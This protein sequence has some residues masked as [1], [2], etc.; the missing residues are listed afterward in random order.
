MVTS[1]RP[2]REDIA[3]EAAVFL[4][5][6]RLAWGGGGV[7]G[8]TGTGEHWRLGAWE[9]SEITPMQLHCLL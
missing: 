1:S 3:W 8:L 2:A 6:P 5:P 9:P 7:S 4:C